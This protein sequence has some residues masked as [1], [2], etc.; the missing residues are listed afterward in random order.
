MHYNKL[1]PFSTGWI[2][3]WQRTWRPEGGTFVTCGFAWSTCTD[4]SG[5]SP[6]R[7][8]QHL[9]V[10]PCL[11]LQTII[12]LLLNLNLPMIIILWHLCCLFFMYFAIF[13]VWHLP[14]HNCNV[15]YII[16]SAPV[17]HSWTIT[18]W[19]CRVNNL[20]ALHWLITAILSEAFVLAT[21]KSSPHMVTPAAV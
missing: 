9:L 8:I 19:H 20:P 5:R 7:I 6:G 4:C 14:G 10:F 13:I 16:F 15:Y 2:I 11:R 12:I 17:I 21:L 18:I 1:L 3:I